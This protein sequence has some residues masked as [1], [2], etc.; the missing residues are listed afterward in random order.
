MSDIREITQALIKFR[1][2]RNW[3]QFHNPK[4]LSLA[5]S[6]EAAELNELFL[7]KG[8]DELDGVDRQKV[9][10]EMADILSFIFL[11]AENYNI[12]IKKAVLEKIEKNSKKY[13]VEKAK[14][15]SS[16]YDQL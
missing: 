3:K 2:E 15:N 7:W 6:I 13:P 9:Q 8:K 11:L 5:V 10:D 4:D 14:D 12:D 1:D 16:K